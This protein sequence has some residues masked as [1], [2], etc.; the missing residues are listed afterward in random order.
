MQHR[1]YYHLVWTTRDRAPL[2]DA[3]L[4]VFLCRFLRAM[5]YAE[6]AAVLEIGMVRTHVHVLVVAHPLTNI[7]RLLQR[8]KGGSAAIA[9]REGHASRARPLRWAPGYHIETVSPRLVPRVRAYVRGQPNH[10]A[11]EAID[12]WE[13]DPEPIEVI[14]D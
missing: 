5:G 1:I 12:G 3:R 13:K 4:A 11:E 10:H 6:R 14:P 7:P 8:M 2:I 9:V